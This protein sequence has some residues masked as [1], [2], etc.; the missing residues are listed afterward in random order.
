L[1]KIFDR[2]K[3]T[4]MLDENH[5]YMDENYKNDEIFG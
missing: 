5:V 1:D 3:K 2:L 4:V